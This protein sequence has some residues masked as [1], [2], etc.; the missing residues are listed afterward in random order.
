M[1]IL[2]EIVAWA[3]ELIDS[4]AALVVDSP[5]TY[6]LV[7]G[8]TAVDVIVPLLP[9]EA[10][11]TTAAVLAGTG[12]LNIVWVMLAA[13]IGAFVGDNVAYWIGRAAGRPLVEKVMRGDT[14]RLETVAEQFH[15]RGGTLIIVGRFV[16]GGRTAIAIGAGVLHYP[17]LKFIAFDAL[18]AV[19]W[20]FQASLPGYIGGV[21][22]SDRPWLAL[23]IGFGLSMFVAIAIALFQRWRGSKRHHSADA[24]DTQAGTQGRTAAG[25]DALAVDEALVVASDEE[26]D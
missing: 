2:T 25:P 22:V 23:V 5:W 20:S 26:S 11:V 4:L 17:W 7:F 24:A 16:P 12:Q 8:L 10:I 1:E 9:A 13:G 19:I 18:A 15:R 6:V 3:T 21:V 14:D